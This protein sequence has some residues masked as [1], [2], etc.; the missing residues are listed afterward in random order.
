MTSS[1]ASIASRSAEAEEHLATLEQEQLFVDTKLYRIHDQASADRK[2]YHELVRDMKTDYARLAW[3]M[4]PGDHQQLLATQRQGLMLMGL[5]ERRMGKNMRKVK[6]MRRTCKFMLGWWNVAFADLCL[7]LATKERRK[8]Y[9]EYQN[10]NDADDEDD[11][12][13]KDDEDDTDDADNADDTDDAD[14]ADNARS[15][16]AR[17]KSQPIVGSLLNQAAVVVMAVLLATC[18][19]LYLIA[20]MLFN[21]IYCPASF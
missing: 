3:P 16:S 14:N 8:E 10:A 9:I 20:S 17:T 4:T 18:A 11:T 12:D 21:G 5:Y 13:D 15:A 6:L 7:D 19:R 1:H 2:A